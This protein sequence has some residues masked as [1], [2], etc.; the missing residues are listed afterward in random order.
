M[1][2]FGIL[3][4]NLV[5]FGTESENDRTSWQIPMGIAFL[6]AFILAVGMVFFPET[7]R[8][9]FNRGRIAQARRS[10]SLFYG[11]SQEHTANSNEI[12]Q[13]ESKA[14]A[15]K[16]GGSRHWTETF[17]GPSMTYRIILGATLQAFQQ[18]TGANYFFYYGNTVFQSTGLDNAFV[19][20]IILGSV[21][22]VSTL[23]GLWLI[24][25]VSRRKCLIGGAAW[26]FVCFMVFASLGEFKLSRPDGTNDPAI[27]GAMIAFSCLFIAAFASTWGPLVWTVVSEMYPTRYRALCI[28]IATASNW[29]FTFL[30]AFFTPFITAGIG[31]AYGYVF[32]GCCFLAIF[33]VYFFVIESKGRS[34][35]EIDTM[36]LLRVKPWAS[37]TWV[38]PQAG[39]P[40]DEAML[41][42]GDRYKAEDL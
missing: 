39:P 37:R 21:N 25:T 26:M 3:V 19:T 2:T 33:I 20:Q 1:I 31:F 30:I 15:E 28:G 17:T 34:L 23:F 29:I 41:N 40:S 36:Y 12:A 32:G 16:R 5:V 18:L 27:G 8:Y 9:D 6:W 35:E 22:F 14:M 13:M 10:L 42:G 7:P 4:G 38:H 24:S 11:V